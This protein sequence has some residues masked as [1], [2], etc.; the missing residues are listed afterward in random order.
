[1]TAAAWIDPL[2]IDLDEDFD[3]LTRLAC[4]ISGAPVALLTTIGDDC[5]R[6]VSQQGLREP[7]ASL[8]ATPL[9]H[10]FC[11]HVVE[12]G[13]ALVVNEATLHPE[14]RDNPAIFDLGVAAYLGEPVR[15]PSGRVVGAFCVIDT[16]PRL[17]TE[18]ERM[19]VATLARS[20]A[21]AFAL[22]AATE[23][24][25]AAMG[26][27]IRINDAL[28]AQST[29]LRLARRT[30]E[31]ALSRQ[32]GFLAGLSHEIKTP[33]NGVLGGLALLEAAQDE[34]AR[35]R[36]RRMI[37]ASVG[38]LAGCVDD[39][40]T[41]CRLGAG[42]DSVT[43]ALFEPRRVAVGAIETVAALA[44]EKGLSVERHVDPATPHSWF[45]DGRRIEQVLVNLLGNAV[46]Y[47]A[48]GRVGVSVEPMGRNLAF[49]VFDS[50]PGVPEAMRDAI[51]EPFNRGDPET[52]RRAAGTGLGLA[53]A[54]E[55]ARRLGGS[56]SVERS[57]PGEGSTFLLV[58]PRLDAE[59]RSCD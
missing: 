38:A 14:L 22:R 59:A 40:V 54:R 27:L 17:W 56:L 28:S 43:G 58:A 1:M 30:A 21:N 51:F 52:A 36:C 46:K 19:I 31:E 26:D 9:S 50:G 13:Q 18:R 41:Y 6:F 15:L 34:P 33:L 24:Q 57:A 12:K 45:S 29:E 3:R 7:W 48:A 37:R 49:R 4:M 10:S 53:I 42:V 35:E 20:A 55:A 8:R 11:R 47:T 23:A 5:Q 2:D 32:T 44:A 25:A 39:L 16:A